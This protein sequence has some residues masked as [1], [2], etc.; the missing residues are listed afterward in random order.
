MIEDKDTVTQI[1]YMKPLG[2][3]VCKDENTKDIQE[4]ATA[5]GRSD[6]MIVPRSALKASEEYSAQHI[7]EFEYDHEF[8]SVAPAT[9]AELAGMFNFRMMVRR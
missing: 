3:F 4:V 2:L 7:S 1:R 5:L 8:F 6:L 9:S